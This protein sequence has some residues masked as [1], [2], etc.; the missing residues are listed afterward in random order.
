MDPQE[1]SL[2]AK[3]IHAA[4]TVS[5]KTPLWRKRR[6]SALNAPKPTQQTF[7]VRRKTRLIQALTDKP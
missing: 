3:I 7:F 4:R 6:E 2:I 1:A 5:W